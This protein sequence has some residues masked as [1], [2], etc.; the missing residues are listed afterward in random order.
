MF[1]RS[2]AKPIGTK[3]GCSV[4][5]SRADLE[6]SGDEY[7]HHIVR[8]SAMGAVDSIVRKYARR[9][10]SERSELHA[11]EYRLNVTVLTNDE[12]DELFGQ[13]YSAGVEA[14]AKYGMTTWR[15]T[16]EA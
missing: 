1:D 11:V 10:I 14:G 12:L 7:A 3:F 15:P 13:A 6:R 4:V 2:K 16:D 8:Q 5:I 9:V